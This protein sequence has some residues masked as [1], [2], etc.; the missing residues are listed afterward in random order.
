MPKIIGINQEEKAE[1]ELPSAPRPSTSGDLWSFSQKNKINEIT[2]SSE[3][4]KKGSENSDRGLSRD[5]ASGRRRNRSNYQYARGKSPEQAMEDIPEFLDQINAD[6]CYEGG[7]EYVLYAIQSLASIV[8][9]VGNPA[10]AKVAKGNG[11]E[12]LIK[13]MW[14][15]IADSDVQEA[16]VNL[17]FALSAS[18]D[19]AVDSDILVGSAADDAVDALLI[20]MQTHLTVEAIQLSACGALACLAAASG[21]NSNINDGSLSGSLVSV[22]NAMEAHRNSKD[23]QERGIRALYNQCVYSKHA[24]SNKR[25]L[26]KEGS[27]SE[28]VYHA[29]EISAADMISSEFAC[30]LY[31]CLSASGEDVA[32]IIS[33]TPDPLPLILQ[34]FQRYYRNPMAVSLLSTIFGCL[35][36]FL[37]CRDKKRNGML[38][39]NIL[40]LVG[41]A[42]LIHQKNE[43][44]VLE[45]LALVANIVSSSPETA[46]A[47]VESEVIKIIIDALKAFPENIE[48]FEEA[49]RALASLSV[50]SEDAKGYLCMPQVLSGLSKAAER[51]S[52]SVDGQEMLCSLLSSLVIRKGFQQTVIAN[53]GVEMLV[54]AMKAHPH[55]QRVQEAACLCMRNLACHDNEDAELDF[56]LP[57]T[58][59]SQAMVAHQ[60][61]ESIQLNG[62]CTLWN[63]A[64]MKNMRDKQHVIAVEMIEYIVKA[65]QNHLESAGVLEM[66]CGA[67]WSQIDGSRSKV[68]KSVDCDALDAVTCVLVVNP[69]PATIENA[70]GFLSI[71]SAN[72]AFADQLQNSHC[73]GNVVDAMRA[74][75]SSEALLEFGALVLRNMILIRP[76][77]VSES[78]GVITT[79]LNG[80]KDH[81]DA[82][83]FQREA[84]SLLWAMTAVS[85]DCKA[86]VLSLDGMTVLLGCLEH[87][88]SFADVQDAALG[89][90]NQ[91]SSNG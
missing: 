23:V 62:C 22:I 41:E 55:E 10:K 18:S 68:Q 1:I 2:P 37:N 65:I 20:V 50:A 84:C 8:W 83:G 52:E 29:L 32:A 82:I 53:E 63:V 75:S 44:L 24:E 90:F 85:E 60:R 5:L 16:A 87:N 67:L 31:W 28:V 6:N 43:N 46:T 66:A 80:M 70:C 14:A 19:G 33:Q 30:R 88:G 73:L 26:V 91:L 34:S 42:T 72:T 27:G 86:K 59:V 15:S 25:S 74:N 77:R 11:I 89:A 58:L 69:N 64:F 35:A 40:S 81:V 54:R 51:H 12:G 17:L 57:V 38:D 39:S 79:I 56:T 76:D 3:A 61:S 49:M 4:N 47:A 13:S 9:R 48:I 36:N 45:S 78:S 7:G 71:V 21:T